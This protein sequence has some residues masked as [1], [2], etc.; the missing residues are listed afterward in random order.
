MTAIIP[1]SNTAEYLFK[2][3][4]IYKQV[5]CINNANVL[6]WIDDTVRKQLCFIK[7][8]EYIIFWKSM[9]WNYTSLFFM[10]IYLIVWI[11]DRSI[12]WLFTIC[13]CTWR[14]KELDVLSLVYLQMIPN[15]KALRHP[16][17]KTI[18]RHLP[19]NKIE[20]IINIKL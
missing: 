12:G 1:F 14:I 6:F 9:R 8:I 19:Q 10:L 13:N 4:Q 18:L 11:Y 16:T 7:Y 2:I 20:C 3:L 17:F 5:K 15:S